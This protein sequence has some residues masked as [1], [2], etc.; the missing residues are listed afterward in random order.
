MRTLEATE[1]KMEKKNLMNGSMK[2]PYCRLPGSH[3]GKM[4]GKIG[5]H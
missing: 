2:Y 1:V 3:L 5:G 4:Y